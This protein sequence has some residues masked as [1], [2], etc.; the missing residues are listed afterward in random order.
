[1]RSTVARVAGALILAGAGLFLAMGRTAGQAPV[2]G[3][4]TEL[5]P[6]R[7]N[8]QKADNWDVFE[9]MSGQPSSIAVDLTNDASGNTVYVATAGGGVW[10]STNGLADSPRF[11]L[12]SD[13]NLPA[14]SG[15]LALDSRTNPPTIYV[16]TG[17]P[18]NPSTVNSYTGNGILVS[19]DGGA[20]WRAVESANGGAHPFKG[21]GIS[22]IVIDPGNPGVLLAT[23]GVGSDFN[24]A[25][26]AYPQK[27]PAFDHLGIYRST[28]AGA[29][30]NRVNATAIT[31]NNVNGFF[32]IDLVHEPV[33]DV[34]VAGISNRGLWVSET[35]LVWSTFEDAGLPTAGLPAPADMHRVSL[36]TRGGTLWAFVI[37][38]PYP[39]WAEPCDTEPAC[40][41]DEAHR[42][43]E[44]APGAESWREIPKPT[45]LW[46]K[47]FL[48]YVAAPPG[49]NALVVGAQSL[50]RTDDIAAA[51]P[52][53]VEI[54]YGNPGSLVTLHGD[55][56]A[57]AFV[58]A[59]R[60]YV[61]DDGGMFATIDRG[62]NWRS[63]NATLR[64]T[65]YY[66]A[67]ANSAGSGSYVGGQQDNGLSVSADGSNWF[68]FLQGDGMYTHADA[69][70]PNAFF[71]A[72][73]FGGIYYLPTSAPANWRR[74]I[75]FADPDDSRVSGG[76]GAFLTPYAVLPDD[77]RVREG[78]SPGGFE[79]SQARILLTGNRNPWLAAF[80]PQ[81]G[82]VV[83]HQLTDQINHLIQYIAP[84]PQ[85]ATAAYVVTG[86]G[87]PQPWLFDEQSYTSSLFR[88]RNISFAGNASV[89]TVRKPEAD[90]ADT[91]VLGHAVMSPTCSESLYIAKVG[92]V[93]GRKLFK[94]TTSGATWTNISGNLPNV[95]V[96][97]IALDPV[98]PDVIYVGT[99]VGAFVA[100]DGGVGGE[101]WQKLGTGLPNV[102]VMHLEVSAT[103]KLVAATYGRGVWTLDLP[104]LTP[105]T[106][107]APVISSVV[108]SQSVLWPPNHS[109]V[110]VGVDYRATDD[111]GTP[112]CT[113][114]VVS[115]EPSEGLGDGDTPVDFGVIDGHHVRLRAERAARGPGRTYTINVT[116]T[117]T[118][119]LSTT[120]STT[121]L[122]PHDRR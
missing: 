1:M 115:S 85:D 71:A 23:T 95:P 111:C 50:Y 54:E 52:Q 53:W 19:R 51:D 55:Q 6:T 116:C 36:A 89:E 74:I 25:H 101:Q 75:D 70:D 42:L 47:G 61:G 26:S 106:P 97:W 104:A 4:W 108:T 59:D 120:A 9:L 65:E 57:V 14:S 32:H 117:G 20:T 119:G 12:L 21:M 45:W 67:S 98:N 56:H 46:Y 31:G 109:M 121:V 77:P 72:S 105:W 76:G 13:P 63:L 30:W 43:F 58:D 102:P 82:A 62:A 22:R 17:D 73:Q 48:G 37:V 8:G 91:D 35:G 66:S 28:D 3:T 29:S 81:N 80:V 118:D 79:M 112:T 94:T 83:T 2:F 90:T 60:W 5:G 18:D 16:G 64:T 87:Q 38:I 27:N 78:L 68:Q 96:H 110:D 93:E 33:R 113:L 11:T 88:L 86:A 92:W 7:F 100:T 84:D 44:L 40:T 103:R 24:F 39:V 15:A 122:V 34:F 99:N 114:S 49:S 107:R 10:K 41:F 69:R